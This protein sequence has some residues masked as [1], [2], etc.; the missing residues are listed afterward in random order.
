MLIPSLLIPTQLACTSGPPDAAQARRWAQQHIVTLDAV[1]LPA[2]R[3][4]AQL[5][6]LPGDDFVCAEVT[7]PPEVPES[8]HAELRASL[9]RQQEALWHADR[10]DLENQRGT[11]LLTGAFLHYGVVGASFRLEGPDGVEWYDFRGLT[12]LTGEGARPAAGSGIQDARGAELGYGWVDLDLDPEGS[13]AL[14]PALEWRYVM[15]K[16]EAQATVQLLVQVDGH[17]DADFV[18]H[19]LSR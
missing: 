6:S 12:A 16:R 18:R 15:H 3:L 10:H 8:Q 19:A 13:P 4:L 17:P 1:A 14:H 9:C 7:L 5:P 11:E 2:E